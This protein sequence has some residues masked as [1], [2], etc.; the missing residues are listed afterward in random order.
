MKEIAL[1]SLYKDRLEVL[2]KAGIKNKEFNPDSIDITKTFTSFQKNNKKIYNELLGFS[3]LLD[4]PSFVKS[5]EDWLKKLLKEN[6]DLKHRFLIR[7]PT[8]FSDYDK[9]RDVFLGIQENAGMKKLY[10]PFGISED[11]VSINKYIKNLD[12]TKR[13]V[14]VF[15]MS[16]RFVVMKPLVE[17]Y[18]Q[19][20]EIVFLYRNWNE[21]KEQASRASIPLPARHLAF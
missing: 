2:R 6:P 13:Y 3:R 14:L 15:D 11:E 21:Y 8:K 18:I 17:K 5:Q 19:D 4:N 10:V 9:L 1:T 12:K 7:F 16:M 20:F